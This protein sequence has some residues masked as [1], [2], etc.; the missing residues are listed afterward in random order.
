M[1]VGEALE[2]ARRALGAISPTAA[3]DARVLLA[4]TVGHP[5][6]WLWA[7]EFAFLDPLQQETFESRLE[8]CVAGEPLPYVLGHWE[9]FG[10]SFE[11]GPAVLIPRPETELLVQAAL[12]EAGR[13]GPSLRILDL[14]TGSGCVAISLAAEMPGR[15]IIA[16][17]VSRAALQVARRNA[18]RHRVADRVH[19]VQACLLHGLAAGWELICANLP[20]IPRDRLGDL[21]VSAWEPRLALDGGAAGTEIT[22]AL[23]DSLA[24][25]LAPEATVLLEIDEGQ[26]EPLRE[27]LRSAGLR[28]QTEVRTD[29]AGRDRLLVIHL[30]G[31]R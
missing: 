24:R 5:T 21:P 11:V 18:H 19:L 27:G 17:D 23:V 10:R 6:T 7:N 13:R 22:S 9:F 15:H 25:T 2:R 3:G 8:R 28:T 16:S 31:D 26:A 14:G 29:L 20:Y 12:A 30:E 1:D 4:D